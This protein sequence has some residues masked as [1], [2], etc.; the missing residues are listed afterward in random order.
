[1][2]DSGNEKREFD[3]VIVGGGSAGCVLASRLTEDPGVS[4]CLLEAG[5]VDKSVLIHCPAGF[6]LQARPAGRTGASRACRR[7]GST[8]AAATS[9]A[10]RCSAA[11]RR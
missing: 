6:A 8:G 9:R 4:V 7:R 11:R 3:Y 10:A 2:S 1:M 5:P